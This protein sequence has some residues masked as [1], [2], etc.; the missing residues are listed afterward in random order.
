M[1][2]QF[3]GNAKTITI[4]GTG[5]VEIT[6]NDLYSRWVD[7]VQ[8]GVGAGFDEVVSAIGGERIDD[9]GRTSGVYVFIGLGWSLV[10][11]SSITTLT[12]EG[13]VTRDPDDTSGAPL[14]INQGAAMII[15][16]V[17]VVALGYSTGG[18]ATLTAAQVWAH[19]T[20]TLTGA[21]AV[22]LAAIPAIPTNPLLANDERLN[23]LDA[24]ISEGFG[25]GDRTLLTESWQRANLDPANPVTRAKDGDDVVETFGEVTI[26]HEADGD[27]VTSTRT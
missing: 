4:L 15:R 25:A 7:W 5:E 12:V 16:E 23:N 19:G 6:A 1:P 17:S 8:S 18:G 27:S 11:P 21:Q 24:P 26:T 20:R 2:Y 10:V 9:R 13:N 3:D 14:Y 22:S